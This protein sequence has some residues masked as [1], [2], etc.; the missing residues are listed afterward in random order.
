M[1]QRQNTGEYSCPHHVDSLLC[2]YLS[3]QA[4]ARSR[5][6]YIDVAYIKGY[7]NG[8]TYLIS[9][10]KIRKSLPLYYVFGHKGDIRTLAHYKR[11]CKKAKAL[12][13]AAYMNAVKHAK[14]V[15]DDVVLH[16]RALL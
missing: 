10:D 6:R 8:L 9:D 3:I 5:R 16:H 12:H 7:M 13:R 1:V 11:V 14:D 4:N 15:G 2:K